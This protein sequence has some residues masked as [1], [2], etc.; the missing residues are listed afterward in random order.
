MGDLALQLVEY[1]IQV[2]KS[3]VRLTG[4]QRHDR[5]Q[6]RALV[7]AWSAA[8]LSRLM[9]DRAYDVDAFRAWLAPRGIQAVIPARAGLWIPN[10]ATRRRTRRAT[11]GNVA[12]AGS[13]G[14]DAWPPATTN[15]PLVAWV[16]CTWRAP[17]SG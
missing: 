4:G 16:F 11:R 12:A 8:P 15:T 5:T 6:A 2:N 17:G 10:P 13:R 9:A 14:G 3:A 7:E 1:G